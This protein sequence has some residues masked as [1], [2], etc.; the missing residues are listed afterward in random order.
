ML[1]S[2]ALWNGTSHC[3]KPAAALKRTTST[4]IKYEAAIKSKKLSKPAERRCIIYLNEE[5]KVTI[6]PRSDNI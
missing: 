6:D 5:V 3:P 1:T 4:H 2:R